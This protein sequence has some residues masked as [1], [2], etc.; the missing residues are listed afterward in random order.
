VELRVHSGS[1]SAVNSP[2][3]R[4]QQ[5]KDHNE[6]SSEALGGLRTS[7]Y[8]KANISSRE[9]CCRDWRLAS[10]GFR[11]R[12]NL[13]GRSD[14]GLPARPASNLPRRFLPVPL[15]LRTRRLPTGSRR[16]SPSVL[17]TQHS[18]KNRLRADCD[19]PNR[20]HDRLSLGV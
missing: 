12:L 11:N 14:S 20:A 9:N 16:V 2:K 17:V 13:A 15:A 5:L 8:R 18:A 3:L 4:V 6:S 1:Q 10:H 7:E 19:H